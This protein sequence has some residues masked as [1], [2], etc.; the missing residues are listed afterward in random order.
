MT[1]A[2]FAASFSTGFAT[3]RSEE[4]AASGDPGGVWPPYA[5]PGGG[6]GA[7][8]L[9]FGDESAALG[10]ADLKKE[11]CDFWDAQKGRAARVMVA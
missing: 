5:V 7:R 4:M 9:V 10:D 11:V 8:W 3:S 6:G 2:F 1:C